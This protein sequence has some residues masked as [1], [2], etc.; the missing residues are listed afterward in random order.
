[1]NIHAEIICSQSTRRHPK[2]EKKQLSSQFLWGFLNFFWSKSYLLLFKSIAVMMI[3]EEIMAISRERHT[4]S[5]H[6]QKKKQCHIWLVMPTT[7]VKLHSSSIIL[8][9]FYIIWQKLIFLL[10]ACVLMNG[11]MNCT[12]M[13][14]WLI[15]TSNKE[16]MNNIYMLK[17]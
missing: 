7:F 10:L 16:M 15:K 12:W 13:K 11:N 3:S 5:C 9:S 4:H 2:S 14:E 17:K 6:K 1:M 8:F